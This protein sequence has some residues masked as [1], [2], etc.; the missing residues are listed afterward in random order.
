[1]TQC[2]PSRRAVLLFVS[3]GSLGL[4]VRARAQ[5][6]QVPVVAAENFYGDLVT[7]IGGAAVRVTSVLSNPDQDPHLFEVSP[8]TARTVAAA[9]VV[10]LNGAGY[11][12]WMERLLG[13]ARR[14]GSDRQVVVAADVLG[15]KAGDNPHLWYDPAALPT[16]A[17]AVAGALQTADPARAE[18]YRAGLDRF[19]R[20]FHS[21]EERVAAMRGRHAGVPVTATEPVFGLMAGALGLS[22]RNERFQLATM[23]GTEPRASDVAA[24]E[25]DLRGKRVRALIYNSQSSSSTARRLLRLAASSS[26]PAVGVTETLPAGK[27]Y[28]AW[29][30]DQLDALDRALTAQPPAAA[31]PSGG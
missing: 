14:T 11:D 27:T 25:A 26:V 6:A 19:L 29:M 8:S 20:A 17:R 30:L 9:R 10:V 31:R 2:A 1:M 23:N 3:G 24:M 4:A 5:G 22:M 7:Q 12:S 16:M 18:E 15:R 21:V 28:Q 13:T